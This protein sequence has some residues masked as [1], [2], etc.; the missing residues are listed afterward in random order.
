MT[1]TELQTR[2]KANLGNRSDKDTEI[3]QAVNDAIMRISALRRW[4]INESTQTISLVTDTAE[5]SLP[6]RTTAII[7]AYLERSSNVLV[8]LEAV[9]TFRFDRIFKTTNEEVL[10]DV[11]DVTGDH[12]D[13]SPSVGSGICTGEPTTYCHF[14]KKIIVYP[15]PTSSQNGLDIYVRC[16]RRPAEIIGSGDNPLGDEFDR[17]VVAFATADMCAQLSLWDDSKGWEGRAHMLLR[18]AMQEERA[19]PDWT[20]RSNVSGIAMIP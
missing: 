5:Y 3:L 20:P 4:A 10:L 16:V 8:M 1:G 11:T 19:R 9:S 12:S 15:I 13:G 6:D 7:G 17:L 2:I 18:E 14:G